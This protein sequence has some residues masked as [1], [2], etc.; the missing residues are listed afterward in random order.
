MSAAEVL[1]A[2][3]AAGIQLGIN[4]DDLVLEASAPPSP[5]VLDMLSRHK[6]EIA[7]LLMQG[8]EGWS[9]EDWRAFYDERAG[10][11]EFDCDQ[12][13]TEAEARAFEC[14]V[15]EWLNQ[16]PVS[17][18]PGHCAWCGSAETSDARVV[19]YGTNPVG[20]AWLHPVC[21]DSWYREHRRKAK[22]ALKAIG[23]FEGAG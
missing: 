4:G 10:I 21:W 15:T 20:S 11:A 16:H 8:G 3:R 1:K 9:V 22:S 2:A 19:P 13:R 23:I 18:D 14:C 17:S 5:A 7:T 6:A 12:T